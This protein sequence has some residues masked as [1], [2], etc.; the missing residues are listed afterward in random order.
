LPRDG[1]ELRGSSC[2]TEHKKTNKIIK[3]SRKAVN[4]YL[5]AT[6]I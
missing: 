2:K 1:V 4:L 6:G 5:E 3:I